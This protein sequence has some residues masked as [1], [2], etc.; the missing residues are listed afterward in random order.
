[1]VSMLNET[2]EGQG[3]AQ[4]LLVKKGRGP[5]YRQVIMQLF[6]H[7]FLISAHSKRADDLVTALKHCEH[8]FLW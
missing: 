7:N 1:M 6:V 2:V 5:L 8:V 4:Q 3:R